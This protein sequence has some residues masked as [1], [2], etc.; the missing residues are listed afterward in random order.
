MYV[1]TAIILLVYNNYSKNLII[2]T[3]IICNYNYMY[4]LL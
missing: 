3:T 2:F 4:Y 1:Q